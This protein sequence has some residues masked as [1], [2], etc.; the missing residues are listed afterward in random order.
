MQ[1]GPGN[2]EVDFD[3]IVAL[4]FRLVVHEDDV[5]RD[6]LV[7]L[8]VKVCQFVHHVGIDRAGEHEVTG[9]Q[10]DMHTSS[11]N[12]PPTPRPTPISQVSTPASAR[13]TCAAV[14]NRSLFRLPLIKSSALSRIVRAD[15]GSL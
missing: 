8:V 4:L 13:T 5:G 2:G 14:R 9:T 11:I 10:V 1:V 12:H 15:S 3:H 7:R 6:D